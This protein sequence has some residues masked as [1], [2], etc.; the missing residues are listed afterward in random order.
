[1]V[2]DFDTIISRVG[3]NSLSG[4]GYRS[5]IF[6]AGPELQFD[7]PD[8]ELIHMWV[9]DMAF[10]TPDAVLDAIRERLNR[11]ILGYTLSAESDAVYGPTFAKWAKK[12]YAWEIDL[13]QMV[14][15]NGV[16]PALNQLT[17]YLCSSGDKILT[18]TPSYG[19]FHEAALV[20]HLEL[21]CSDLVAGASGF[22][23]DF[24]D[25][26]RKTADPAV[27][28]FLLCNPHN[29][30][31]RCWTRD[32]LRQMGEI[33][34]QNGVYILSDEIHCDLLRKGIQHIPMATVFPDSKKIATCMAPSKTFNMAGLQISNV[35]IPDEKLRDVWHQTH[36]TLEN[37][38]S[39]AGA[40]GAYQNGEA[41]LEA[42]RDYLDGNFRL[43]EETLR[44]RLPKTAFQIP[45]A[46]YLAWVDMSAYLKNVSDL[47]DFFVNRA[48]VLLEGGSRMFIQNGE[49]HVRLNLACPRAVL[50]KG[51]DQ[52]CKA[53]E[54]QSL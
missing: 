54:E 8:E 46:T 25:F 32:E 7:V 20:N 50:R 53:V 15:S 16:V 42:L 18:L 27:K 13:S 10:A 3:T 29:P 22:E 49:G 37:P 17:G 19:M 1:M 23:I 47:P 30:T 26:R 28:V 2:Y 12:H 43:L 36:D 39:L 44:Q 34:E 45:Q 21:V 51:L 48:G 40:T 35:I 14:I 52:I 41:W 31:G 33:C 11:S 4:E 5:Y 38:L 24:D 6:H 9:A